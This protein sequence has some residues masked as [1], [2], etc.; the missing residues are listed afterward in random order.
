MLHYARQ[1]EENYLMVQTGWLQSQDSG[2][3]LKP[4][5]AMGSDQHKLMDNKV[6]NKNATLIGL[7]NLILVLI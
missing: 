4:E 6:L 2:S 7:Y 1:I 5:G 3:K